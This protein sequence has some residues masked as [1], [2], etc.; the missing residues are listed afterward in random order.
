MLDDVNPIEG[1]DTSVLEKL[2]D[3]TGYRVL[4]AA[5]KVQDKT[6]GGVILPDD[7]K[8]REQTASVVGLV[9]KL[10]PDAYK[11]EKKFPNGAYCKEGDFV[12]FSAY[13]GTRF[14]IDGEEFRLMNDDT[15]EATIS[16][17]R[18]YRRA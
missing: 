6:Q 15:I 9:L 16:D 2:P 4:I 14:T 10:G 1:V 17:P 3:P 18:G 13:S 7:L 8:N 5:I 11:D 12:L